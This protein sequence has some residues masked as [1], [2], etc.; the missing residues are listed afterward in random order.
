MTMLL[1][2]V[3]DPSLEFERATRTPSDR[4]KMPVIYSGKPV[5]DCIPSVWEDG[6]GYLFGY[7]SP[8]ASTIYL[9]WTQTDR[10]RAI[11]MA[12]FVTGDAVSA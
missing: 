4:K 11:E 2:S 12:E 6:K 3:F 10:A 7:Q 5:A 1:E 8:Y 9:S